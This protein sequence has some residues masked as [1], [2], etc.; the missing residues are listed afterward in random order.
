MPMKL[1]N[2]TNSDIELSDLNG[3]TIPA[4]GEIE[5]DSGIDAELAYSQILKQ[6][7]ENDILVL[8]N[9]DGIELSKEASLTV[10]NSGYD[11][12]IFDK[13]LGTPDTEWQFLS[14]NSDGTKIWVDR[15]RK[16]TDDM[17]TTEVGLYNGEVAYAVDKNLVIYW[18]SNKWQ[19]F[20]FNKLGLSKGTGQPGLY[21]ESFEDVNELQTNWA[22]NIDFSVGTSTPKFWNINNRTPSSGTGAS[23]PTDGNYYIYAEVSSGGHLTEY[24]LETSNFANLT[25]VEFSYHL[26]GTNAGV[27]S[28]EIFVGTQYTELFKISGSQ[29][30]S[31]NTVNL[32]AT[33]M[34]AEKLRFRYINAT[35]YQGD[36]CIDNVK[37]TSV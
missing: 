13:S 37:I 1:K 32:D 25:T 17:L 3:I 12:T 18:D 36:L 27:F 19:Y 33:G 14:S 8:V 29:G 24:I 5:C 15:I 20:T 21:I 23:S 30:S 4:N 28:V 10:T 11:I 7:I 9:T 2:K 26:L 6:A 16:L 31:W 22:G 35:G 34:K